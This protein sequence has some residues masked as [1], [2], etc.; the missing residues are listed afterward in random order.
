MSPKSNRSQKTIFIQMSDPT[1]SQTKWIHRA[2]SV[3]I[4]SRQFREGKH[5]LSFQTIIVTSQVL[6]CRSILKITWKFPKKKKKNNPNKYLA[7]LLKSH[8]SITKKLQRNQDLSF[9][10]KMNN[11]NKRASYK[12]FLILIKIKTFP[13]TCFKMKNH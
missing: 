1:R 10:S 3:Q 2:L 5:F 13:Q 6:I 8:K 7:M 12:E 9:R 4:L 11:N